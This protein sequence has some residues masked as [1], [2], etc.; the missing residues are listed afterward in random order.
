MNGDIIYGRNSVREALKNGT[1]ID[2]LYMLSGSADR[3][4]KEIVFLAKQQGIVIK[5]CNKTKLD[6]MCRDLG[7]EGKVGNHQGVVAT[8]PAFKYSG[9]EDIFELAQKR[10]EP[11]FVVI[12]DSIQA[13]SYTHLDVYKRQK[14]RRQ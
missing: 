9:L 6:D 1:Q 14:N 5:E 3:T 11:P 10:G 7:Y 8:V 13:V 12:L 2:K 4:L